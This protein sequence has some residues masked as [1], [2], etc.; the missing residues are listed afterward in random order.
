MNDRD[1]HDV[2]AIATAMAGL[3]LIV[4]SVLFAIW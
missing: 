3:V 1:E 2:I 4:L